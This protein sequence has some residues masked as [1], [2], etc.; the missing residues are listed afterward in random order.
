MKC[1][2]LRQKLN[3][4]NSNNYLEFYLLDSLGAEHDS[5]GNQ[6]K[7]GVNIMAARASGKITAFEWSACSRNYITNFLE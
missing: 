2:T 1:F 5:E 3:S 4:C 6:C 7:D